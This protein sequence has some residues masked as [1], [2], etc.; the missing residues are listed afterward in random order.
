[1]KILLVD[2]DTTLVTLMKTALTQQNYTVDIARDGLE[3]WGL[4]TAFP[5]D[6]VILDVMLPGL[7]GIS[8]CRRLRAEQYSVP[9]LLLSGR[10]MSADKQAGLDAGADDYVVKPFDSQE[11]LA[12]IRALLRRGNTAATPILSWGKLHLDP[13]TREVFYADRPLSLTPKEYAIL[14]LFLRNRNRVFSR[15]AILD[16]LWSFDDEPPGEET[17]KVHIK[18][19]RYKFKAVGAEA[20]IETLYGQGYR[21][22]ATYLCES[23]SKNSTTQL[24]QG[25]SLKQ[26]KTE[27]LEKVWNKTKPVTFDR[28][29]SLEQATQ[30]LSKNDL[31]EEL[32]QRAEYEAHKLAGSMGTFGFSQGSLLARQL[33]LIFG[34][35]ETSRLS[36]RSYIEK[37]VR[38]LREVIEN[39]SSDQNEVIPEQTHQFL[40]VKHTQK[41][42]LNLPLLLIIDSDEE[43]IKYL[44]VE[45]TE[46]KLRT[47]IASDLSSARQLIHQLQ[48]DVI[49]LDHALNNTDEDGLTLLAELSTSQ[50]SIPVIVFST[51]DRFTDRMAVARLGVKTFLS[52]PITSDQV[53][54][55]VTQSLQHAQSTPIKILAVDDDPQMLLQLQL[56][57][58]P[59]GVD[60]VSLQNP[61]QF[62][63]VLEATK[64]N[65]L[66]LD[67]EMPEVSGLE[68]CQ[69]IR[70]DP[71]WNWLPIL[72]ISGHTSNDIVCHVFE[73]G[74][75]DYI[76]KPIMP[77]ELISRVFNRIE[78]TRLLRSIAEI[79]PLTGVLNRSYSTQS[80][81]QFLH[82][83]GRSQ[84]PVSFAII[85]ICELRQINSK[86]GHTIGDRVMRQL[87]QLLKQKFRQEDVVACWS[88]SEFV[89]GMYGVTWSDC[90]EWLATILEN[91]RSIEFTTLNH[92]TFQ[93]SFT[94][95]V[96][97]YPSDGVNLQ[98]LYRAAETALHQAKRI[99]GN[100]VLSTE[101]HSLTAPFYS[102]DVALIEPNSEFAA[103]VQLA[104]E[105]RGYHVQHFVDGE[106]AITALKDGH[107]NL[108][109]NLILLN[110]ELPDLS[111]LQVLK[112]L[113]S[114]T[115]KRS[116]VI[117]LVSQPEDIE[118]AFH[119][120]VFDYLTMPYNIPVL[121]QRLRT[122]L[123]P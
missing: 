25:I 58:K 75:D 64:P 108:Q 43:L 116:K 21:L 123:R 56:L 18:G 35:E 30:A 65:L 94:A 73:V 2:D 119:L 118:K 68:L 97:Q 121:V 9:V 113:G 15:S 40:G 45:A 16:Q 106:A 102:I 100:C 93:V 31:T 36:K 54:K 57:L 23:T 51:R 67:I 19:L 103:P 107:S 112:R 114:K 42:D 69:T 76:T 74:A 109:A 44:A 120:G 7:D 122:A 5:Y 63:E 81:E 3:G 12:R 53:F 95:G 29:V 38:E 60:F 37:I 62:W 10:K 77:A 117:S 8:F 33:E 89:V 85:D 99:G 105:T 13:S 14:E 80:L 41:I 52:K 11:L 66:I 59:W 91:L 55:A 1:M 61:S 98:L 20:L 49:L 86:F 46:W 115:L 34:L 90:V 83:A 88:G 104:L 70:N 47:A 4:V 110:H 28:L 39:A 17:V 26:T 24:D 96:A 48:P 84:Q 82:L 22:N 50:T 92:E 87:G 27:F 72:F 111:G 32:R 6:L 101:W 78:R 79:D 71:S